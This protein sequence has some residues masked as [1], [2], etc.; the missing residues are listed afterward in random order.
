MLRYERLMEF[1]SEGKDQVEYHVRTTNQGG[2]TSSKV[3]KTV[4]N[5]ITQESRRGLL[6][7]LFYNEDKAS[8]TAST[9][10]SMETY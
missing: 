10:H 4:T 8:N 2:T 3:V 5:M 7:Y 1:L 9:F 6:P